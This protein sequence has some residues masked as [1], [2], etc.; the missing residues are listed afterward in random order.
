MTSIDCT[1]IWS[2]MKAMQDNDH[3]NS[4]EIDSSSCEN[5]GSISTFFFDTKN[6]VTVCTECGVVK[7]SMLDD[8]PEWSHGNQDTNKKDP[9]RCGFPSNPL[10]EKSS[11]NTY[12]KSNKFS[13]MAKL[14]NQMSMNHVERSLFHVFEFIA[15]LSN[16]NGN[17]PNVVVE[18][19]KFYYKL[20]SER[21]LSRGVIRKGLISCCILH[22]C[23][24][25]NVTR[26]VKEISIICNID[27]PIINKTNKIFIE[28][29]RDVLEKD[30]TLNIYTSTQDLIPR[31]CNSIEFDKQLEYKLIKSCLKLNKIITE[32]GIL[33]GKTPSSVVCGIIFFITKQNKITFDNKKFVKN[34]KISIVTV[35]KVQKTIDSFVNQKGILHDFIFSISI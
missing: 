14:H 23:K 25:H 30:N 19:A 20:I 18:Q 15:R 28:I 8:T 2:Q 7:P 9:S 10:L 1:E 17:L 13:F 35:N 5:C 29:M 4:H 32:E 3:N 24:L 6:G 12:I 34:Q 31:Y 26:S 33:D 22:S 21:K 16:D 27:V 11:L